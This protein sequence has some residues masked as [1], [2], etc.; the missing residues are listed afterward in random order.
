[1]DQGMGKWGMDG[2]MDG[3][4]DRLMGRLEDGWMG[5]GWG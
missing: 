4:T 2:R 3:W 5:D 1:M